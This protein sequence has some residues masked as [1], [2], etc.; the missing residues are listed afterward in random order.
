MGR[1]LHDV[2]ACFANIVRNSLI[3]NHWLSDEAQE[4]IAWSWCCYRHCCCCPASL[5]PSSSLAAHFHLLIRWSFSRS[6]VLEY[7]CARGGAN[8]KGGKQDDE[9]NTEQV[10]AGSLS[11]SV[12]HADGVTLHVSDAVRDSLPFIYK[13][14]PD[15]RL[16]VDKTWL[17]THKSNGTCVPAGERGW[18]LPG[19]RD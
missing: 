14:I 9:K 6:L 11:P 1:K 16:H 13:F 7:I 17:W 15:F 18:L 3:L 4:M 10:G 19:M 12:R 5:F 2:E 8:R